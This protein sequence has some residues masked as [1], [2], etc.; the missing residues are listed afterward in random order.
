[1]AAAMAGEARSGTRRWAAAA[2]LGA[3][4]MLL[5]VGVLAGGSSGG[6]ATFSGGRL[7]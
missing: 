4:S 1:M 5:L 6:V 2:A 7:R 3:V